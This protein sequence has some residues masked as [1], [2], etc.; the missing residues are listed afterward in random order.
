MIA[1]A[2]IWL[3]S[4]L[5]GRSPCA[6]GKAN[7]CAE[8]TLQDRGSRRQRQDCRDNVG[9]GHLQAG[10][11]NRAKAWQDL[12]F[13]VNSELVRGLCSGACARKSDEGELAL[14]NGVHRHTRVRGNTL[15]GQRGSR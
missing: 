14:S 13:K 11:C 15:S 2:F 8:G 1:S 3:R 9:K 10:T 7:K 4:I 5:Y 12:L 6:S